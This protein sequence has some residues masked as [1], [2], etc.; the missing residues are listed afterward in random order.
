MNLRDATSNG[1]AI[2]S[3]DRWKK[4]GSQ[5]LKISVVIVAHD[6]KDFLKEALISAFNQSIGRE[7]FEVIVV[8]N[9]NDSEIDDLLKKYDATS[10]LEEDVDV[11]W[12]ILNG[13]LS[14]K[15]EILSFLDY[16]DLFSRDKL[17]RVFSVFS[18]HPKLVFYHNA[19]STI[20]SNNNEI[21]TKHTFPNQI[22]YID[23]SQ[24]NKYSFS[25]LRKYC[26]D[27]NLSSISI[28]KCSILQ[29]FEILKRVVSNTDEFMFYLMLNTG[30]LI[31]SD[32]RV[33]SKYRIHMSTSRNYD[34]ITKFQTN[35]IT[36]SE[37]SIKTFS[38]ICESVTS[39]F[40]KEMASTSLVHWKV[41]NY[42]MRKERPR[43]DTI[44]LT[45]RLISAREYGGLK[46]ILG[47]LLKIIAPKSFMKL[48]FIF[49][50]RT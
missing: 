18:E 13:A 39:P 20:D 42:L 10:I 31:A 22:F 33:L 6:R 9:F 46:L 34:E 45:K 11:G 48:F 26:S 14:A 7:N 12:S 50:L 1:S 40:L 25:L 23:S 15:G 36:H 41:F 35:K 2:R 38:A 43:L 16:D 49:D 30:G 24:V 3:V 19:F 32:S 37:L 47:L 5:N 44:K 8:K 21:K 17:E 27:V 4:N 29:N 28:R